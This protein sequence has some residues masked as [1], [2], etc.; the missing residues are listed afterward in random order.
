MNA[1]RLGYLPSK[2]KWQ[3]LR[4]DSLRVIF[5]EGQE[6][7]ARRVG[8]LMLKLA[9]V[10]PI[11]KDS[12]YKPISVVLQPQTNVSNGYVGLAPYVSEF[13]IQPNENPFELG[14]L[15]WTDLLALH[16]YRHVQ[17][18]NAVNT[19]ISHLVKFVL[20][21]LA[22]S[23]MYGLAIANWLREGDAVK[24]E[25]KWTTQGRGRLSRFTLPFGKNARKKNH[26]IIISCVTDRIRCTHRTII[27]LVISCN[28]MD[29]MFLEK[30]HGIPSSGW[31]QE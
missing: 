1:Q 4:D 30:P 14:S 10:D 21:D 24:T 2:T 9:S 28:N 23:G 18:L 20:G 27:L 16:E 5:P 11:A 26:G 22:F 6:E 17:Q 7:T 29:P 3:Q 31:P 15:P 12:R 8:Y 19:G 25:T 13:F